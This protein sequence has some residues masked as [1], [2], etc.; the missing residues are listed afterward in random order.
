RII[1]SDTGRG[2]A[3][4]ELERVFERFWRGRNAPARQAGGLGLG[5][6]IARRLVE[7]H[8]G[9]IWAESPGEGSG[10]HFIGELP[11]ETAH[12]RRVVTR[13]ANGP[14]PPRE[15]SGVRILLVDDDPEALDIVMREL[16][17]FGATVTAVSSAREAYETIQELRPHLLVSDLAMP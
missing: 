1:V 8:G 9:G 16:Q 5:L 12:A 3:E 17:P 7:M 4:D 11:L 13:T 15:L 6:S 2:I 14:A 10:A